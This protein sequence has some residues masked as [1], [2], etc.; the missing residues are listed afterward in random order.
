MEKKTPHLITE[1]YSFCS[2]KHQFSTPGNCMFLELL[3]LMP[4]SSYQNARYNIKRK[5]IPYKGDPL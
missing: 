5:I 3:K 4:I 2:L 1:E